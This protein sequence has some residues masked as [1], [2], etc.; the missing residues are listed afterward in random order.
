VKE[1]PEVVEVRKPVKEEIKEI[2]FDF[3]HAPPLK[4]ILSQIVEKKLPKLNLILDID[5][6]MIHAIEAEA[7]KKSTV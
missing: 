7:V 4:E 3:S 5:H 6:T 1:N 2:S